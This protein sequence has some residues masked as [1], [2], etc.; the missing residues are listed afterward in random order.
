MDKMLTGDDAYRY[1]VAWIDCQST[2]SR[3]G[4]SVLT[5]G[6]HARLEDLPARLRRA[7][8]RARAFVPRHL[9]RVPLT[10]PS[11][12][13]NPLTVGA[14]NEFW[15]RKA[16]MR[17]GGQAPPHDRLLPPP[18]R[19]RRVEPPLRTDGASSST[20]SWCPTQPGR[21]CATVIE[22]L[23]EV[24]LAS[25]PGRAQAVRTR[26]TPGP[27]SFPM[28]GWTLALDLPGRPPTSSTGCSTTST[29]WCWPPAAASTW[30]RTP[31]SRPRPPSG[32]CTPGRRACAGGPAQRVDPE[33]VL[34]SD[35]GRRLGLCARPARRRRRAAPAAAP[36]HASAPRTRSDH[37]TAAT[38]ARRSPTTR[39]DTIMIDATGRPQSV[40]V[41]GGAS[42]I[43]QAIVAG[44]V[45]G[46]CRTV[47]LAGRPSERLDAAATGPRRP[48]PTWSRR[49]PSTPPTWPGHRPLSTT[50]SSRFG[51]IDLVVA[52][53]GALGDQAALESRPAGRGRPDHHQL[54]RAG[55]G[56]AGRGRPHPRTRATVASS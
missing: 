10:P 32:P 38:T 46:R 47:V 23:T 45:P 2:G 34:R 15:F 16:P 6:D 54:H 33:G 7:P 19:G 50:C 30:P 27:L 11:G 42:E 40:L 14:F 22:R 20:S 29:S 13:L 8:D 55:R 44:L 48:G 39:T 25:L 36:T 56:H 41:L 17:P 18:R 51:D 49:W 5:R 21:R 12:L 26:A 37:A 9:A 35:L 43:A 1:S 52:A 28:P 31:G 3:L 4:R 53:A 24:K